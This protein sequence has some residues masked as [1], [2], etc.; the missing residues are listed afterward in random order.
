M[1]SQLVLEFTLQEDTTNAFASALSLPLPLS[2]SLCPPPS[3][4]LLLLLPALQFLNFAIVKRAAWPQ[5]QFLA[6]FS[7]EF[8]NDLCAACFSWLPR[9]SYTP[10]PPPLG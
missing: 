5:A 6:N 3:S 8:P 7:A 9:A 1:I 2:L 4:T 10:S